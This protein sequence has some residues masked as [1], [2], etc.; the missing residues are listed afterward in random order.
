MLTTLKSRINNL[1]GS[2]RER[3]YSDMKSRPEKPDR[4][5]YGRPAFLKL[6]DDEY[7]SS[8]NHETRPIIVPKS[9]DALPWNAGYAECISS[10]VKKNEDQTAIGEIKL[11]H[12][13]TAD[14][15]ANC[16]VDGQAAKEASLRGVYFG[17]FDG[18]GG[19]GA[20]LMVADQLINHIQEKLVDVQKDLFELALREHEESAALRE[21]SP[22]GTTPGSPPPLTTTRALHDIVTFD[23]LITGALEAAF[24]AMDEHIAG[25]LATFNISGGCCT[26]VALFLYGRLYVANA[27]DCRAVAYLDDRVMQLSTD[28]SADQD[29]DRIYNLARHRP[30]LTNGYFTTSQFCRPVHK[31]D[32]GLRLLCKMPNT[33]GWSKR[34]VTSADVNFPLISG[35]K[36]GSRLMNCIGISR[37][38]GD[39][40]LADMYTQLSVKPFISPTPEVKVLDLRGETVTETDVVVIGS[41]GL[42]DMVTNDN[43]RHVVRTAMATQHTEGEHMYGEAA[44]QAVLRA[45]GT[46]DPDRPGWNTISGEEPSHDDITALVIPLR[47]VATFTRLTLTAQ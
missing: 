27:G 13:L 46:R 28:F 36:K 44:H 31:P 17:V 1:K 14:Q 20:A 11:D 5:E 40:G 25:E 10:R 30:E 19:P 15:Q 12:Q 34:E 9:A 41:D 21:G 3:R 32:V 43:M 23:G 2:K 47:P 39:H 37:S 4:N 33:Q 16:T 45:R 24:H 29:L 35:V 18:H 8:K 6:T 26:L 38:L 22:C 42:W 7:G